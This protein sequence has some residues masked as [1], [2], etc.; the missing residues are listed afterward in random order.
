MVVTCQLFQKDMV[1]KIMFTLNT[2]IY[3]F[4][5]FAGYPRNPQ[6]ES[7]LQ[8]LELPYILD[9]MSEAKDLSYSPASLLQS[10]NQSFSVVGGGNNQPL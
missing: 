5:S 1:C 3:P 6:T 8:F 4:E 10:G 9:N 2:N 7:F